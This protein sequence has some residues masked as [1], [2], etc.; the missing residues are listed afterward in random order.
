MAESFLEA[1]PFKHFA[2]F[3]DMAPKIIH[4]DPPSIQVN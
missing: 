2:N 3:N 4:L 1:N